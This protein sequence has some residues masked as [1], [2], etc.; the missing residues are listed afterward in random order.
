MI[1][2][3]FGEFEFLI[4]DLYLLKSQII[5]SYVYTI[6][7]YASLP[8]LF[9]LFLKFLMPVYR[10]TKALETRTENRH[11]LFFPIHP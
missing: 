9:N 3:N 5:T 6:M 8:D 1:M 2:R 10:L 11:V 7:L 4:S